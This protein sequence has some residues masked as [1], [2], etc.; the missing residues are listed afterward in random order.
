[1]A[2][3]AC[4]GIMEEGFTDWGVHLMDMALWAKDINAGPLSVV[5]T[6]GN[7]AY[8]DHAHETFDTMNVSWQMPDHTISWQNTAGVETGPWGRNYGLAF[9][10]NDASI[11]IDRSIV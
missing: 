9:I 4:F 8:A 6:G 10:G 11:V 2:H 3:G 5:A 1:M 7:F